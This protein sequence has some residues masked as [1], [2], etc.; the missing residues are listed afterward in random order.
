MYKKIRNK[1]TKIKTKLFPQRFKKFWK[2]N[3]TS[4]NF[5][6][7][8][9]YITDKFIETKSYGLVSNYW[10]VLNI[11]NYKQLAEHGL[12]NYATTVA[13]NYHTFTVF[14]DAIIST[15][16]TN[17]YNT[18]VSIDAEMFKKHIN[19]S[20][21]ESLNYNLLVFIF[22]FQLKKMGCF[23]YLGQLGDTGYFGFGDPFLTVQTLKVSTDKILS[24]LDYDKISRAFDVSHCKTILEIGAGSGRTSEALIT[25]NNSMNYVICDIPPA[26]YISY[27]RLKKAFP[28]KKIS[29][30]FDCD[31][32]KNLYKNILENDISFIFPHQ[33][34]SINHRIFDLVLAID[35]L[36]E[37]DKQ[38]IQFY[39]ERINYISKNCY[40]SIWKKTRVPY[41]KTYMTRNNI[42]DFET[43]DYGIPSEWV[44]I[45]REDLIFPSN[46]LALGYAIENKK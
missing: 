18:E 30:L 3:K 19:F 17:F 25:L 31:G 16:L 14:D 34:G 7:D 5:D 37:M 10:H 12:E 29:V 27:K 21:K 45:F 13:R 28:G 36:H 44:E 6:D 20:I 35:C 39:L 22:Y 32:E 4:S 15:S 40:F 43:G 41:S 24:I 2:K 42:L 11:E 1:F 9:K 46:S 23:K 33:L 26:I 38:T 8:L